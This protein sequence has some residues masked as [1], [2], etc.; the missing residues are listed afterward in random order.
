MQ[1]QT[2]ADWPRVKR[3]DALY[4]IKVFY[5]M[6]PEAGPHLTS[7]R[8]EERGGL[9]TLRSWVDAGKEKN[10]E[11]EL[12]NRPDWLKAIINVAT[13]GGQLQRPPVAPP[14]CIV[15]FRTGANY[16]LIDFIDFTK[17]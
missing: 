5:H 6:T 14:T 15:W 9:Y 2:L 8:Y 10:S 3:L 7:N 11:G 16:T 1:T 12:Q 17:E 4:Q 13:I